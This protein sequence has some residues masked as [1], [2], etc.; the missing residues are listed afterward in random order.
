MFKEK[1][2]SC[3][4]EET[5]PTSLAQR[6]AAATSDDWAGVIVDRQTGR[7]AVVEPDIAP[8]KLA[9]APGKAV[10]DALPDFATILRPDELMLKPPYHLTVTSSN[11]R[12]VEVQCSHSPTLQFLADYLKKWCKV[13]NQ[14]S[15]K[16]CP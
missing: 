1:L 8:S 7:P 5:A 13:N 15:R 6:S 12:L 14:D 4:K 3:F 16:V 2:V 9:S 11:A 10:Y